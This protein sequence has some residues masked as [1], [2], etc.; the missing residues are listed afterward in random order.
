M[1]DAV[2]AV[3]PSAVIKLGPDMVLLICGLNHAHICAQ[4]LLKHADFPAQT[5]H[6][7]W[8]VRAEIPA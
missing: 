3:K 1:N 8:F 5:F 7:T 2:T 6:C 4:L